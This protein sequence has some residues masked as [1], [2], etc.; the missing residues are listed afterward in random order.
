MA[1]T[2]EPTIRY[3][4]I[5]GVMHYWIE[6]TAGAELADEAE[7]NCALWAAAPELLA[8]CKALLPIAEAYLQ[9]APSHPDNAKLE[10]VRAAIARAT[11]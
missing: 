6:E 5:H 7:A 1:H 3:V 11:K 4:E 8:A 9:H 10:D 2:E